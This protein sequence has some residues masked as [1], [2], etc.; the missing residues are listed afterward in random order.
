MR[1]IFYFLLLWVLLA[2]PVDEETQQDAVGSAMTAGRSVGIP[3]N[4][5]AIIEP[6]AE[7]AEAAQEMQQVVPQIESIQLLPPQQQ[8]N[9]VAPQLL[10]ENVANL[11]EPQQ[12]F[13]PVIFDQTPPSPQQVSI[14]NLAPNVIPYQYRPDLQS[15]GI[16]A[17]ALEEAMGIDPKL[18]EPNNPDALNRK[19]FYLH[20]EKDKGMMGTP[21]GKPREVQRGPN[22]GCFESAG[23]HDQRYKMLGGHRIVGV[24]ETGMDIVD[25]YPKRVPCPPEM[26]PQAAKVE[27]ESS[28][29]PPPSE[30][31]PE[32]PAPITIMVGAA[33][34][35]FRT[36][37]LLH[38]VGFGLLIAFSIMMISKINQPKT[39]PES[40]EFLLSPE[41]EL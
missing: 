27:E 17:E 34:Q 40:E 20:P 11:L 14:Q 15:G 37:R 32:T 26:P 39:R 30:A 12:Q 23:T 25:P 28:P 5:P 4:L 2:E 16:P 21:D 6:L 8:E 13:Q 18:H 36:E 10:E 1:F 9:D 3:M 38:Y 29:Q 7:A 41:N 24:T 35:V 31:T 19:I 22:G 33:L